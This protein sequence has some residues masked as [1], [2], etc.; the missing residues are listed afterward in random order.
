MGH[1]TSGHI[2]RK[3]YS[4]CSEFLTFVLNIS[5]YFQAYQQT[6]HGKGM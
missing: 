5:Q 2:S 6:F 3:N 4:T 1:N